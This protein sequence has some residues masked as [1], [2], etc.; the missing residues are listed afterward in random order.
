MINELYQASN[1]I[2]NIPAFQSGNKYISRLDKD[3]IEISIDPE[4]NFTNLEIMPKED[5]EKSGYVYWK[6][7]NGN[8]SSFPSFT[9]TDPL[10]EFTGDLLGKED[11]DSLEKLIHFIKQ[12]SGAQA[13]GNKLFIN[14]A[15]REKIESFQTEEKL[16]GFCSVM[17][18]FPSSKLAAFSFH[19]KLADWLIE[20]AGSEE[21]CDLQRVKV[22]YELL[23]KKNAQ[24]TLFFNSTEN[25]FVS[26]E[27]MKRAS[28]LM[29]SV[30]EGKRIISN[31]NGTPQTA[32]DGSYP[33]L[34]YP[35]SKGISM[36]SKNKDIQSLKRYGLIGSDAYEIGSG[37]AM[38]IQAAFDFLISKEN[39]GKTWHCFYKMPSTQLLLIYFVEDPEAD[40]PL[41]ALFGQDLSKKE[42]RDNY[43]QML[44][45]FLENEKRNLISGKNTAHKMVSLSL[46]KMVDE[47]RLQLN[48]A[49]NI[50][51]QQL[52]KNLTDWDTALQNMP[53]T[54]LF[55][56]C[57]SLNIQSLMKISASACTLDGRV[58]ST[59]SILYS[60]P[61]I[62]KVY[63]PAGGY[64]T[65]QIE[66]YQ[67]L[68]AVWFRYKEFF[69]EYSGQKLKENLT[70]PSKKKYKPETDSLSS[71]ILKSIAVF[72]WI[73]GNRKEDYMKNAP[74]LLGR[75]LR[76]ADEL[77]SMYHIHFRNKG[78]LSKP[79]PPRL[80]GNE[81]L[82]MAMEDPASAL[83]LLGQKIPVYFSWAESISYKPVG[84]DTKY[85]PTVKRIMKDFGDI[86]LQLGEKDWNRN[87]D[88]AQQAEVL[89]GYLQ[90]TYRSSK[91]NKTASE[92]AEGK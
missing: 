87:M 50:E 21:F 17:N 8:Q 81:L 64:G 69:I 32:V 13:T 31:L 14:S 22:I 53:E 30:Q 29:S 40:I 16:S 84:N 88:A 91:E 76:T 79:L 41:A 55:Y 27:H 24:R 65:N 19:Q 68:D 15:N 23:V 9:F 59:K 37:E 33:K 28:E 45:N 6:Y 75:L 80:M 83:A 34:K 67:V 52:F 38:G 86:S 43:R 46:I 39:K 35:G 2:K 71:Q 58:N 92:S 36:F 56:N 85:I 70:K 90:N 20:I 11:E 26:A 57:S 44:S 49:E 25:P 63:M 74:Y 78:D 7:S 10:F 51:R 60:I 82:G 3:L 89:L 66:T 72:L 18:N 5:I 73:L 54:S 77:H 62:M 42:A 12:L 1:V 47:G 48:Y 4:G 61:E